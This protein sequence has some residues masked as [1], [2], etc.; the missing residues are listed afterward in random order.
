[1]NSEI[2]TRYGSRVVRHGRSRAARAHQANKRRVN[3]TRTV[4]LTPDFRVRR[5]LTV[6]PPFESSP[7]GPPSAMRRGGT[8]NSPFVPPLHSGGWGVRRRGPPHEK[9]A[10]GF[11]PGRRGDGEAVATPG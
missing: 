6:C 11:G 8:R 1:M 2:S 3:L 4:A 7:P 5:I 9:G 10:R